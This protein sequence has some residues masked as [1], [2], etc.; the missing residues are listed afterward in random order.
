VAERSVLGA[1]EGGGTKFVCMVGTGPSDVVDDIT[2]PTTEPAE[3]IGAVVEF[4]Q[5][6]RPG[7]KLGA[8]G[9]ATF[10]PIGLD[11]ASPDYGTVLRTNKTNWIGARILAP[12]ARRFGVPLGWDTDVNGAVL[13]EARWGAAQGVDPAVYLTI[14]TG[15]G[16]GALVNGATIH[17]LLHPEMGH[18]PVPYLPGD[19]FPGIC[20]FHGHCLEGV[21]SGPALSAR[22]TRPLAELPPDDPIWDLAARYIAFG[23]SSIVYTLAPRRIVLGGGVMQQAQLL[24]KIRTALVETIHGYL[25]L[26]EIEERIDEYVVRSALGQKAGLFGALVLAERALAAPR[27]PDPEGSGQGRAG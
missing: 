13:G 18:V 11:P 19:T 23:L 12:L 8:I 2:I 16:G 5:R 25:H 20:S 4:F 26:P 7:L 21:A 24:P 17:G 10:G 9:V 6:P 15:I 1:V 14:G 22:C 27:N 3:T